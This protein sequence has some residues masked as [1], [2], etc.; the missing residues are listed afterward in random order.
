MQKVQ[1]L[2]PS[3]NRRLSA[4]K[5]FVLFRGVEAVRTQAGCSHLLPA[6]DTTRVRYLNSASSLL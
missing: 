6:N 5:I 3:E 2:K 1:T 4:Q